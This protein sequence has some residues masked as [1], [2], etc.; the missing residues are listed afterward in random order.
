MNNIKMGA[1][2]IMWLL[3]SFVFFSSTFF[4]VAL[5]DSY[6]FIN[7]KKNMQKTTFLSDYLKEDGSGIIHLKSS[8]NEDKMMVDYYIKNG[9]RTFCVPRLFFKKITE[10]VINEKIKNSGDCIEFPSNNHK[11]PH[12]YISKYK[13]L[14]IY[15]PESLVL[16]SK[17]NI[18]NYSYGDSIFMLK[19]DADFQ[20]KNNESVDT[21][22]S[23]KLGLNKNEYKL[24][25]KGNTYSNNK[26]SYIKAIK[27][28]DSIQST[29]DIGY[30]YL[31]NDAITDQFY[32]FSLKNN[33]YFTS[34]LV[35]KTSGYITGFAKSDSDVRIFLG[36]D[37]IKQTRILRG[38]YR[39]LKP[40]SPSGG[41]LRV[42]ILGDDGSQDIS[43][44][45]SSSYF[46]NTKNP[47][48][49]SITSGILKESDDYF[50][51][52]EQ[53]TLL[54]NQTRLSWSGLYS[55]DKS[56]IKINPRQQYEK[57]SFDLSH[58]HIFSKDGDFGVFRT[59]INA[60]DWVD[61]NVGAGL[62]L[63]S[64]PYSESAIEKNKETY[65]NNFFIIKKMGDLGNVRLD[66]DIEKKNND[67]S[68]SNKSYGALY[69]KSILNNAVDFSVGVKKSK[70][71]SI[72]YYASLT[73]PLGGGLLTSDVSYIDSK[74]EFENNYYKN[75]NSLRLNVG[76]TT[77][78]GD[79]FHE[80][81]LGV[82]QDRDKFNY[83]ARYNESKSG[84]KFKSGVGGS[85]YANSSGVFFD[86]NEINSGFI[87]MG[88]EN[89]KIENELVGKDGYII[90]PV[91]P[92]KNNN[93]SIVDNDN[94]YSSPQN[95]IVKLRNGEIVM[96][97][98]EKNKKYDYFFIVVDYNNQP[99]KEGLKVYNFEGKE[100]AH[101]KKEGV[102][103]FSLEKKQENIK[104]SIS[105]SLG[106][107]VNNVNSLN[108]ASNSPIS[109]FTCTLG[110]LNEN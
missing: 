76:T 75:I 16:A 4:Q 47:D 97:Y 36:N 94:F 86:N 85:V 99:I 61:Y 8:L 35:N 50:F 98:N 102:I 72:N 66:Y 71:K 106:C 18:S 57:I 42:E 51:N 73:I 104:I 100:I 33:K 41:D 32:G 105:S 2:K 53:T 38:P 70:N 107:F 17:S 60:Y 58:N 110:D 79:V 3:I 46:N 15:L 68:K 29:L 90:K 77:T 69:F 93:V 7:N 6:I 27:D 40:I 23:Y 81:K 48:N 83:Y 62:S 13:Y 10:E 12:S 108:V 45:N 89:Q 55:E 24:R 19:Y 88:S 54:S 64:I 34:G 37:L 30:D 74:T 11:W 84:Y 95:K 63:Y 1:T 31:Y 103:N 59:N 65:R 5:A 82:S 78:R 39:I 25:M 109:V 26:I 28:I 49:Y 67:N 22:I 9:E 14:H 52:Y 101:V 80:K 56:A 92:F 91:A 44:V 43:Y 21:N 87:Y 20:K 96:L